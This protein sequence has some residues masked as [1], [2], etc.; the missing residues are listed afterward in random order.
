ML[1]ISFIT[2]IGG[3]VIVVRFVRGVLF[4]MSAESDRRVNG[5][6]FANSVLYDQSA[7]NLNQSIDQN[8]AMHCFGFC[9]CVE[10]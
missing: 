1:G 7:D 8:S 6:L 9:C 4:A 5:I 3:L 10:L 2:I